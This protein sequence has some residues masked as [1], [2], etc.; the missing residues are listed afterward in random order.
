MR[1]GG[2]IGKNFLLAKFPATNPNP[3]TSQCLLM[4][5]QAYANGT[6]MHLDNLEDE[7]W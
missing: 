3:Y 6:V 2:K 4:H 1:A 7:G 5:M